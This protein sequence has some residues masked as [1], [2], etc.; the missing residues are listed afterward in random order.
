MNAKTN[1]LMFMAIIAL[2]TATQGQLTAG[3]RAQW[4]LEEAEAA[5]ERNQEA[6]SELI[7]E[8]TLQGQQVQGQLS[9]CTK[10]G[11]LENKEWIV[12]LNLETQHRN[13]I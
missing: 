6:S 8:K 13:C 3:E 2:T 1:L 5:L 9:R 10:L 12:A 4:N 7:L 11:D